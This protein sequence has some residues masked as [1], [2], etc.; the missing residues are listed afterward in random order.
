[1]SRQKAPHRRGFSVSQI[2]PAKRAYD[3]VL[4]SAPPLFRIVDVKGDAGR[5]FGIVRT[6]HHDV[7]DIDLKYREIQIGLVFRDLD[8]AATHL[9]N[10]FIVGQRDGETTIA[11]QIFAGLRIGPE[12]DAQRLTVDSEHFAR[13]SWAA[14]GQP[15]ASTVERRTASFT[16]WGVIS[17]RSRLNTASGNS[18]IGSGR[19]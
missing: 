12:R 17:P 5:D 19:V 16:G 9:D 14:C 4:A 8:R 3:A 6:M 1:M 13:L 2:I 15:S 7:A 18:T 10:A 11:A